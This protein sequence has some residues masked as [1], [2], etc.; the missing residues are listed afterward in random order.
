[1]LRAVP[2]IDDVFVTGEFDDFLARMTN[3]GD[4]TIAWRN[5][6][7]ATPHSL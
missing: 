7:V 4:A 2:A 5:A 6:L 1:M 3:H